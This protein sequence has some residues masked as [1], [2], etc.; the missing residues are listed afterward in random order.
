V[1]GI[2]LPRYA[3]PVLLAVVLALAYPVAGHLRGRDK[4]RYYLLQLI[5]L[6]GAVVGAKVAVLMGDRFW[7]IVPVHGLAEVLGAGRSVVGGLLFGFLAAEAAKPLLA[8]TLPPNDRFAA[9]LPFS[10]A[11]GRVGCF[12]Q[13]CCRGIAHA[14]WLSV[15]YADGVPRYPAP[16]FEAAFQVAIGV[17]FVMLVRRGRFRGQLF[18]IYLVAYGVYRFLSEF[19]RETPRVM[20]DYSVYQAFCLVM[21]AAGLVTLALRGGRWDEHPAAAAAAA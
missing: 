1:S 4:R 7:P 6:V 11:V 10:L 9:V 8:Y 16:L 15:T 20:G 2:F 13:G 14:G 3:I 12:L 21:I 19:I 18:A 17:V 5:T